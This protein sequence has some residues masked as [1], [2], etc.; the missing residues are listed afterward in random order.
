MPLRLH[1]FGNLRAL[2]G[3]TA[4][5]IPPRTLPALVYLLLRR[6]ETIARDHMA[7]DLWPD[8][9][10]ARG[11]ARL[12]SA[13]HALGRA[14]PSGG[15]WIH[16]D[17]ENVGWN[18]AEPQWLDLAEFERC[19][20]D[21][22]NAATAVE[23]YDGDFAP[24]IEHDWAVRARDQLRRRYVAALDALVTEHRRL[25]RFDT[26]T[27]YAQRLLAEEPWREDVVRRLIA[28][29]HESGDGSG[30]LAEFDR[31]A[32]RLRAELGADPMPETR[33]L[34]DAIARGD[35]SSAVP[36][37]VTDGVAA[38]RPARVRGL[39]FVG[40]ER[41]L[42]LLR[43]HWSRAAAGSGGT[44]AISGTAGAGKSALA[45]EL[46]RYV[47]DNGGRVL[48]GSAGFPASSPYQC[49]VEALR[50]AA[51]VLA[52]AGVSP[53][54][55]AALSGLLPELRA[56]LDGDLPQLDPQRQQ[57]RFFEALVQT[58]L[59]LAK[60][61]PTLLVLEDLQWADEATIGALLALARRIPLAPVLVVFTYRDEDVP[62][63][64]ALRKLRHDLQP[65]RLLEVVSPAPLE[66]DDVV[67]L[68][69]T[70]LALP[71]DRA[72]RL[73]AQLLEHSDGNPLF[74]THLIDI[75]LEDGTLR[76]PRGLRRLIARRIEPLDDSARAVAEIAALA[77]RRFSSELIEEVGGWEAR[78]VARALDAL[79]ARR[80]VAETGGGGTLEYDFTHQLVRAAI[81]DTIA[82]ERARRRHRRIALA[83][84]RIA[85]ERVHEA[86]P[87]LA[88]HYEAAGDCAAAA[89]WHLE[90]AKR[91]MGIAA[92]DVAL[93]HLDRALSLG[94]SRSVR[95]RAL[96]TRETLHGLR[97]AREAQRADIAE[98]E[99][100]ANSGDAT[101]RGEIAYRSFALAR[102]VGAHVEL[103]SHLAELERRTGVRRSTLHFSQAQY[104]E[105]LGRYDDAR[106]A[107][108]HAVRACGR[109]SAERRVEFLCT[110]A[111][112]EDRRGAF[113]AS[114]RALARA[115]RAA[116]TTSGACRVIE[117][118][119][120][121]A[122]V[123]EDWSVLE[124]RATELLARCRALGDRVGEAAALTWLGIGL[125]G[126]GRY[127]ASAERFDDARRAAIEIDDLPRVSVILV[128][129]ALLDMTLGALEEAQRTLEHVLDLQRDQ[130]DPTVIFTCLNNLSAVHTYGRDA[131]RARA[132]AMQAL[133]IARGLRSPASVTI[134]LENLA[135]SQALAGED[136]AAIATME[137]AL[138]QRLAI[139][140]TIAIDWCLANLAVW[141]ARLEQLERARE[142][143]GRALER[144]ERHAAG[145]W[146][147]Y[148]Y[149]AAAQIERRIGAD[150]SATALLQRAAA[151]MEEQAGRCP[152]PECG[153]AFLAL[154]WHRDIARARDG[155]GWPSPP[156]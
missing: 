93:Q 145:P 128:N 150:R 6:G 37:P 154:P 2:A 65:A 148:A 20:S 109:S 85:G 126:N 7:A 14:L 131:A 141:Y 156:R 79:I 129:R 19:V 21:P 39:P 90:A 140:S 63:A 153:R 73:A 8:A 53:V 52:A 45:Q 40:R 51:P 62:A 50:A 83:L 24:G 67:A 57:Q 99:A 132:Y 55:L 97:G 124:E 94:T 35:A 151:L 110:L 54:W 139:G 25:R 142:C 60:S 26:A 4:L 103:A 101:L 49:F 114:A 87:T 74:L 121:R 11:R 102:A 43:T 113:D 34:R 38:S 46:E 32:S 125:M 106:D 89:C 84:E 91:A 78:R 82:P 28:I 80:I 123:L 155:G 27:A 100:I 56:R 41:E 135:E 42:S 23:L 96:L 13:L 111:R 70:A 1:L 22:T 115:A 76:T 144:S 133:E 152:S 147:H 18:S 30:A 136:E 118:E 66:L 137:E 120:R 69:Q 71:D 146:K 88:M 5:S 112:I 134:A 105:L 117:Q 58:M 95:T 149:W 108:L 122:M 31:F 81:A 33:T 48:R 61:R 86:A 143:A 44:V 15:A 116:K 138:N 130:R 10:A 68:I 127:G 3:E 9:H 92:H 104:F 16:G 107:A 75:Y 59:A 72:R 98:L 64:H 29:R 36:F 17:A 119:T 47:E 12:R 77:G